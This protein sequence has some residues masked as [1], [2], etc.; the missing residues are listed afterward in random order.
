MADSFS[1]FANSQNFVRELPKE[2]AKKRS[3]FQ[4][5]HS[6]QPHHPGSLAAFTIWVD[7][8]VT[9]FGCSIDHA[10]V[11][12]PTKI[13]LTKKDIL[14]GTHKPGVAWQPPLTHTTHTNCSLVKIPHH[15]CSCVFPALRLFPILPQCGEREDEPAVTRTGW[16]LPT[17]PAPPHVKQ[18]ICKPR[19]PILF[20]IG[21]VEQVR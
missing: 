9:P 21:L 17:L 20:K 15:S 10:V 4:P 12:Q 8:P 13:K 2:E 14:R 19:Q 18:E 11:N 16:N 5:R 1:P 3:S 6:I 7:H